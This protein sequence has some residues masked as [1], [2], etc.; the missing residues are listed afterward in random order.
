MPR[1]NHK[2]RKGQANKERRYNKV[3]QA[4]RMLDP[5]F[6][7][8]LAGTMHELAKDGAI[9]ELDEV[10]TS[11]KIFILD[12]RIVRSEMGAGFNA[13]FSY[14]TAIDNLYVSEIEKPKGPV[15]KLGE[16]A[17]TG[18]QNKRLIVV[19]MDSPTLEQERTTSY[20][21]LGE[22][23]MR[24]FQNPTRNKKNGLGIDI[25]LGVTHSP[26]MTAAKIEHLAETEGFETRPISQEDTIQAIEDAFTIHNL[27]DEVIEFS[28]LY[29]TA[30]K[31]R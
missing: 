22:V 14:K 2:I 29:T 20:N 3:I 9:P 25:V 23:G 17:V 24:G 1:R 6:S 19:G 27:Y 10:K 5:T 8:R 15:A 31:P 26:V 13:G 12:P 4:W 7:S 30:W 11:H 21:E 18:K 16:V 28:Q